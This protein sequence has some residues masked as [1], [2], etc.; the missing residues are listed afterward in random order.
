M[1]LSPDAYNS[2][3]VVGLV[4]FVLVFILVGLS[5]GWIVFG[6]THREIVESKDSTIDK[7][8][9]RADKDADTIAEL[10]HTLAQKNAV[11]DATTKI[12]SELR[13]RNQ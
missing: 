9:A 11:E 10:S 4:V 2:V 1:S 5:K 6:P 12:L 13:E 3:G 8:Y 7:L